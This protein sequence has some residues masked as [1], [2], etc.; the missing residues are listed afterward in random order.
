MAGTHKFTSSVWIQSGSSP[1]TFQSGIQVTGNVTATKFIGDGSGLTGLAGAVFFA[2]SGSG[3][4]ASSPSSVD[5]VTELDAG[6][7]VAPADYFR[8]ETTSSAG[9][10]PN[11]FV[12]IKL[13]ENG[14]D[15]LQSGPQNFYTGSDRTVPPDTAGVKPFTNDLASG[16]HRYIVYAT[17]TGSAG[18][19][20]AVYTSAFIK[21]YVN[22]EPTIVAPSQSFGVVQIGHDQNSLTHIL[23]FTESFE[24]NQGEG[25]Y[26]RVFS[27]SR[28]TSDPGTPSTTTAAYDLTMKHHQLNIADSDNLIATGSVDP[29]NPT[30]VYGA[31]PLSSPIPNSVLAFTASISNY[32]VTN[33]NTIHAESIQP[34]EERFTITLFDNWYV[35]HSSS[36]EYSMSIVP[37]NT[38]SISNI[39]AHIES[40]SFT[41]IGTDTFSTPIL[42]DDTA[43]RTSKD[44]LHPRYTASLVRVSV[45]ADITEPT[46]Y[47]PDGTHFTEIKL[48][49]TGDTNNAL[50]Y[51]TFRFSGS[52]ATGLFRATAS[53]FGANFDFTNVTESLGFSPIQYTVGTSEIK[54]FSGDT[55]NNLRHGTYDHISDAPQGPTTTLTVTPV[56]NIEISNVRVEVESGSFLT[57]V[58]AF[59]RTASVLY[60]YT[61]SLRIAETSSL[62]GYEKTAEYISES[63]VRVRLLATITEPFGPHHAEMNSTL[64][65]SDLQGG[66][67]T[68]T[69]AFYTGSTET[70][71]S[72]IVYDDQDRLVGNYTSSWIDFNLIPGTY[73]FS[74][75]FNSDTNTGR[76]T[77]TGIYASVLVNAT[78]ATEIT[79]IRYQTETSG[80]SEEPSYDA[81]R[82]V[83][84]GVPRHTLVNSESF[85][86]HT[87]ASVYASHSVSRFRVLASIKEPFGPYHIASQFEKVWTAPGETPFNSVIHFSTG[88]TDT[89]SSAIAY[90]SANRL[91]A[92]Y[93]SSWIGRQ[94]SSSINAS[95]T[96]T[97]TSGSITHNP[98]DLSGFTTSSGQ[99]T[100]LKVNDT[101][102]VQISNRIQEFEEYGHS[103]SNAID[104]GVTNT[105][106]TVLYGSN[107]TTLANSSSLEG[108]P[109]KSAYASQSVSRIRMRT[110]ITE[111]VGPRVGSVQFIGVFNTNRTLTAHTSSDDFESIYYAYDSQKRLVA[112]YTESWHGES[113][114]LDS[115]GVDKTVTAVFIDDSTIPTSTFAGEENGI[116]KGM[117]TPATMI[118]RDTVPTE[119]TNV[120]YETETHGYS[121][122]PS[123]NTTRKVLYGVAHHTN[124]DSSSYATHASAS[125]Y[126]SQSVTQF[127]VLAT[128]TE[129]VGPLHTASRFEKVWT[130]LNESQITDV[131]H[132]NSASTDTASSAIAYDSSNRLVAHYTS[133]WIGKE[134]TSN[135]FVTGEQWKYTSG[136]ILHEPTNENGFTT[137]SGNST[138]I[139]VYDTQPTVFS[140]FKTET[141]THGY[142]KE[143]SQNAIRDVLYGVNAQTIIDS[144]SFAGHVNADTYA[145][146]SVSRFRMLARITEPVGPLQHI[147]S[148][149]EKTFAMSNVVQGGKTDTII[150]STESIGF[151][152]SHSYWT[153]LGE[154]V[155]EYT[156]SWIGES[157][158]TTSD[159]KGEMPWSIS[160]GS[161]THNPPGENSADSSS[162]TATFVTVRNTDNT[163]IDNIIY[164][165]ETFGHSYTGSTNAMRTVLYGDPHVTNIDSSSF[166]GHDS[167]SLYVSH[168]V[169]RF[170]VRARITEPAGPLHTASRF[171]QVWS[172]NSEIINSVIHF[173]TASNDLL[174]QSLHYDSTKRLIVNYTSS[175][176]GQ[177]LSS[178]EGAPKTWTYTSGS[179]LHTPTGEPGFI[180]ASGE[181]TQLIVNDTAQ[182]KIEKIFWET[183]THGYSNIE[184]SNSTRT[185]LYGNDKTTDINSS[186][187]ANH[188]NSGSYASQ[189]VS[190]VRFRARVTEPIG[191]AVN[192]LRAEFTYG[193]TTTN[194]EIQTGSIENG[195][196]S[197]SLYID[198][199]LV[200][201]YTSSFIGREFDTIAG[202]QKTHNLTGKF[203]E[204]TSGENGLIQEDETNGSIIVH[205]TAPTQISDIKYETETFGYSDIPSTSTIRRILYGDKQVTNTGTGSNESGEDW[206]SHTSASLYA[207]H[208]VTRFRV[209]AKITEPVGTLHTASRFERVWQTG[210]VPIMTDVIHFS[211]ASTDTA[212]SAIAYDSSNRLVVDY[213][214]EWKGVGLSSSIYVKDDNVNG[215]AWTYTSGSILHTPTG[216]TG[217]T[218]ASG[219][220]STIIVY[221]TQPTQ[222]TNVALETE[223][224]GY[225]NISTT[226][227]SRK[228]LYGVPHHTL[229]TT[230]SLYWS[231]SA[232]ASLYASQS[233]TRFRIF[234]TIIE[235]MGP[236]HTG[237]IIRQEFTPKSLGEPVK[238]ENMST[239]EVS[240]INVNSINAGS[241]EN[242]FIN[243]QSYE[244]N[245]A[246]HEM[247]IV[248]AEPQMIA[249]V[250]FDLSDPANV[251]PIEIQ[252]SFDNIFYEEIQNIIGNTITPNRS[253][254]YFKIL[255]HNTSDIFINDIEFY[256]LNFIDS[257]IYHNTV[258]SLDT[259]NEA[260]VSSQSYFDNLTRK[261]STYTSS[262]FGVQLSSSNVDDIARWQYRPS[263]IIHSPIDNSAISFASASRTSSLNVYATAAPK[264]E[265]YKTE[266]ET[267]GYSGEPIQNTV[268]TVLY[269]NNQATDINSSSYANHPNSGSYASQSVS[270]FR[271]KV[272]IT[273]PVGPLVHTA[274][275]SQLLFT[276]G[277]QKSQNMI[278]GTQS[279]D[280]VVK[281]SSFNTLGEFITEYTSSWVTKSLESGNSETTWTIQNNFVAHVP[282]GETNPTNANSSATTMTVRNTAPTEITNVRYETETHG[283][284]GEPSTNTTRKVLYGDQ[285]YTC[286]GSASFAGH[287]NAD[288][289]A[290]QS[291]TRFRI[292]ATITEPVGPLHTASRFDKTW[293]SPGVTTGESGTYHYLDVESFEDF[294]AG[295]ISTTGPGQFRN[296][297]DAGAVWKVD[298]NGASSNT[299]PA[300][301]LSPNATSSNAESSTANQRY[302]HT[303]ASNHT[304]KVFTLRTP[305][306]NLDQNT[307]NEKLVLYF[308]VHGSTTSAEPLKIYHGTS[309]DSDSGITELDYK[310]FNGSDMVDG[311]ITGNTHSGLASSNYDANTRFTGQYYRL[312]CDISSLRNTG[313]FYL[314]IS[315][316]SGTSYTSDVAVDNIHVI[317]DEAAGLGT[318]LS[319]SIHFSSASVNTTASS[320]IAYDSS[321]RLVSHY[322]SSWLGK[323][324]Y[325]SLEGE[326]ATSTVWTYTS[327][328]ISHEPENENSFTIGDVNDVNITVY[329]TVNT[330]IHKMQIET[331]TVGHSGIGIQ[332]SIQANHSAVTRSILYGETVSFANSASFE[333]LNSVFAEKSVTRFRILAKIEEPLGPHHTGSMI[334]Y[335][336]QPS[337]TVATGDGLG[338]YIIFSTSS[339]QTASSNVA[340]DTNTKHLI[341]SYTSSWYG[342]SLS[343]SRVLS[344]GYWAIE[345][346]TVNNV[347]HNPK[348]DSGVTKASPDNLYMVVSASKPIQ[349]ATTFE[350]E[351]F[352]SSSVNTSFRQENILYG[353]NRTLS[354]SDANTIGDIWSG[355]AAIRLQPTVTITEPL[356]FRHFT[357]EVTMSNNTGP[358]NK[359]RAYKFHTAS[360]E[361]ASRSERVLNTTTGEHVTTYVGSY[362]DGFTFAEGTYGFAIATNRTGSDVTGIYMDSDGIEFGAPND[363]T[364]QISNTPPTEITNIR[365]E[366]ETFSGSRVGTVSRATTILH[367]NT[368]TETDHTANT[369]YPNTTAKQQ[370]TS[371]RLLADIA[372]PF[373]PH[374]TASIFTIAGYGGSHTVR[375]HTGSAD[376]ASILSQQ[377]YNT[378]GSSSVAYTSSFI[379]I[380][381]TPGEKTLNINNIQH[382]FEN[383]KSSDELS[384]AIL[385]VT[386]SPT[387]SVFVTPTLTNVYWSSSVDID[388]YVTYNKASNLVVG[389]ISGISASAP[390]IT[391]ESVLT[392][393]DHLN[394]LYKE[395]DPDLDFSPVNANASGQDTGSLTIY[396]S[397]MDDYT[398]V[399]YFTINVSGSDILPGSGSSGNSPLTFAVIPAKP[400]SMEGKYWGAA[401][402]GSHNTTGIVYSATGISVPSVDGNTR[403][404]YRA[405]L[406]E[407]FENNNYKS[408]EPA[409]TVVDNIVMAKDTETG[410][411]NYSMS[412]NPFTPASTGNYGDNNRLFD[413]GD[414]GSL[415]VK[416]NGR[417]VVNYDLSSSFIPSWKESPQPIYNIW[418]DQGTASF[419]APNGDHLHS[420]KGRL[421]ITQVRPFNGVSQSIHNAGTFYRHGYQGWSAR[422]EIDDKLYDG[423]NRLDFTHSFSDDKPNQH[424]Q[425]FEWYYDDNTTLPITRATATASYSTTGTEPTFSLSGVSFFEKGQDVNITLKDAFTGIVGSTYPDKAN[426]IM[427]TT[428]DSVLL[429][430]GSNLATDHNLTTDSGLNFGTDGDLLPSV[431]DSASF[432]TTIKDLSSGN[433]V[434]PTGDIRAVSIKHFSRNYSAANSFDKDA[435]GTE[436]NLGRFIDSDNRSGFQASTDEHEYFWSEDYRWDK[437]TIDTLSTSNDPGG[438]GYS[439]NQTKN[440]FA[441]WTGSAFADYNSNANISDTT[442]LQ[443]AWYGS[444]IYPNTD[445]VTSI[446][447]LI[448][449]SNATGDRYYY[450]GFYI[451][452]KG[453]NSALQITIVGNFDRADLYADDIDGEGT[454]AHYDG[455]PIRIDV[456]IPGGIA[457]VSDTET[458]GTDWATATGG[459]GDE[460]SRGSPSEPNWSSLLAFGVSEY[461]VTS[462][463][464]VNTHIIRMSF[465]TWNTSLTRGT[466]LSRIRIK[467]SATNLN[468]TSFK[469]EDTSI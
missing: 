91:L 241:P 411:T 206:A 4:S 426:T 296:V 330:I 287:T 258:F 225:S 372:E 147:A 6:S 220:S 397:Y 13:V 319:E 294:S 440:N 447:T 160:T 117:P 349:V 260:I 245:V 300:R 311:P 354:A 152:S 347:L 33:G 394:I 238:I 136:S 365:I 371:V 246:S 54:N 390:T 5:H 408:N 255:F 469:I 321:N 272:T 370:L 192:K 139:T 99:S 23:H 157:L 43:T 18:E 450:R 369:G 118:I 237:S 333:G 443:V 29:T 40:G 175:W 290:S 77:D 84:Y 221:D 332:N 441:W 324:L 229:A 216:E 420:G 416:I 1:A 101:A 188:P 10:D 459:S 191:P 171:D 55:R 281:N 251:S 90:D 204:L 227:G 38:A 419:A 284:S 102:Q 404:L 47:E 107:R 299:G 97:Y 381:T 177:Q 122:E 336:K 242:A 407:G 248:F 277:T 203:I 169:T 267:F 454:Q 70:A 156:S 234:A 451:G 228:V 339:T 51:K 14:F 222:F 140:N 276:G 121:G 412:F 439:G 243:G 7:L 280:M 301:G 392:F 129:P 41:G 130:A 307:T 119:I 82:T 49:D 432:D 297:G 159:A 326:P 52:T 153:T 431:N 351:T 266:T 223:T 213:T 356:G 375:L 142:S 340:Y 401:G 88:S 166:D 61:S 373:G 398:K 205:D 257:I 264:Y 105:V 65:C 151:E 137:A 148:I 269:G 410:P 135:N 417:V 67:H 343:P 21:G 437:N 126:A 395:T 456:K 460:G 98:I 360:L 385:A 328:T 230:E 149:V 341:S 292:L 95:K 72:A 202:D 315:S 449:Y 414:S 85:A 115:P 48:N 64:H 400:Q 106:R 209:R 165:T 259:Y 176:I 428:P 458:P 233:V 464:G 219:Q 187:Y 71:S 240:I 74:S 436:I 34:R 448:D 263:Q 286:T 128:I 338:E 186:S 252:A 376:I 455:L 212:S 295:N 232:K 289:Y 465:G 78:P 198:N 46:D 45:M 167:A 60:G 20:H 86:S 391:S 316:L 112:H 8:I 393:P 421:I 320:D 359:S 405:T 163:T 423:Y 185:V 283:Y 323:S 462:N 256:R 155:T 334:A 249:R 427:E 261:V 9:F 396:N 24:P 50:H 274:S 89:A 103:A 308:V 388:K 425:P 178:N 403:R 66:I 415:I 434:S 109:R 58:G 239:P 468:I 453:N 63:V 17:N 271:T 352:Y 138:T 463:S 193:T 207:S 150:F 59:E 291:V 346:D 161:V 3:I 303:E 429:F 379:P 132:F 110:R 268:R 80:Y 387:A 196:T 318:V 254:R 164:E 141:E 418:P 270:R 314:Y 445:Y 288:T 345:I 331:E 366:A 302:A 382:E 350:T 108:H 96:W 127:R 22:V 199:K 214:S 335:N 145:S 361:T 402:A 104:S 386:G 244:T 355:S 461:E 174:T 134:L 44:G 87:S 235:P 93:T 143:P 181:S 298:Y 384:H 183:E 224:H 162:F 327:G 79:N 313:N 76:N 363:C 433:T 94:L 197:S 247:Q 16:V 111:P 306:L 123:T 120:R 11:H 422:I 184:T 144:S 317:G 56:P 19:T 57:G 374:H 305:Q 309:A 172:D 226:S 28:S 344:D 158:T 424:W 279:I 282:V 438:L 36:L 124:K 380:Q 304:N 236:Y 467:S 114:S 265:N 325:A 113:I 194:F 42:Y 189:S 217:F 27:A 362:T 211:T 413:F 116:D 358:E 168:S 133:S 435:T 444:L 12:F 53:A 83:L 131:I 452:K 81:L 383:N 337:V 250:E 201:F 30:A 278:F 368:V 154:F 208:S 69:F 364:I 367:G 218:T 75:T 2:G 146:Q 262:Y 389:I 173:Q 32:D 409:G 275:I 68:R 353:F 100:Q 179:I 180:T 200:T 73:N 25:D 26:I 39:R 399:E 377:M 190:R 466:V 170:R 329:D 231:G 35:D 215:Q 37:P 293:T 253:Y 195:G 285:Y 442:D 312:E 273:E 210:S 342:E 406:P 378:H 357:T 446:P 31:G 430:A 348:D 62:E 125:L 92:H 182:V 310:Y 457:G 322:T 15:T